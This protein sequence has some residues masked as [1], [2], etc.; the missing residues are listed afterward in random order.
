MIRYEIRGAGPDDEEQLLALAGHLNTVN[1]PNDRPS[2]RKL[3]DLASKS[4]TGKIEN[5]K[6]R[7]YVFILWDLEKR[8]ALKTVGYP[9][10][11]H[12]LFSPDGNKIVANKLGAPELRVWEVDGQAP[13]VHVLPI[14]DNVWRFLPVRLEFLWFWFHFCLWGHQSVR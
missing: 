3:L 2:V 8:R 11:F 1:L 9:S 6:R 5:P 10:L 12:G 14:Q 7:K 13:S 4:F